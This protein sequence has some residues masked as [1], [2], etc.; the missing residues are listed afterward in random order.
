MNKKVKDTKLQYSTAEVVLPAVILLVT[1]VVILIAILGGIASLIGAPN[2]T[3]DQAAIEEEVWH[4]AYLEAE[5]NKVGVIFETIST[6]DKQYEELRKACD[7]YINTKFNGKNADANINVDT[8]VEEKVYVD[9]EG[10]VTPRSIDTTTPSE[11]GPIYFDNM[12]MIRYINAEGLLKVVTGIITETGEII[13]VGQSGIEDVYKNNKIASS[14]K[15]PEPE[16]I[17]ENMEYTTEKVYLD[18]ICNIIHKMLLANTVESI[19][20][21][22]S[23]AVRYFTYEGKQTV[24]DNKGGIKL[25]DNAEIET[26]FIRAGK[27][28]TSK[29]Y[30]DRIYTQ[31]RVKI[32]ETSTTLNIVLKLNSNVR[33]FDIDII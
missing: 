31:Q 17:S 8:I 6:T 3:A 20:E 7:E 9:N 10:K 11:T 27:S 24:F 15:Q 33:I 32:G 12:L 2:K 30:K 21:A 22:D 13:T 26:V 29:T 18:G 5:K 4:K 14:D 19:R 1:I 23:A 28:D 16:I 25:A